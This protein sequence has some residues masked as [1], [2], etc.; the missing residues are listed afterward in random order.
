M[1]SIDISFNL[2]KNQCRSNQPIDET[3]IAKIKELAAQKL[4]DRTYEDNDFKDMGCSTLLVLAVKCGNVAIVNALLEHG[5]LV[6]PN[7]RGN[8]P[9]DFLFH[10]R[11]VN[12]QEIFISLISRGACFNNYKPSQDAAEGIIK[13]K[14]NKL[15]SILLSNYNQGR[16]LDLNLIKILLKGLDKDALLKDSIKNS[17]KPDQIGLIYFHEIEKQLPQYYSIF[18]LAIAINNQDVLK[19][20]DDLNLLNIK[21]LE[22]ERLID[23]YLTACAFGN[24]HFIRVF[25]RSLGKD[26]DVLGKLKDHYNRDVDCFQKGFHTAV[27][28]FLRS[29]QDEKV[30]DFFLKNLDVS[31]LTEVLEA[32][33]YKLPFD[34]YFGIDLLDYRIE[35]RKKIEERIDYLIYL[36]V[37]RG[38]DVYKIQEEIACGGCVLDYRARSYKIK[39]TKEKIE[40]YIDECFS[41]L[42]FCKDLEDV[43]LEYIFGP[44]DIWQ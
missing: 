6:G 37:I 43:I 3:L 11:A 20:F 36:L 34:E 19:I 12:I 44:K 40:K 16:N 42:N 21:N 9:L 32:A 5:A 30:I 17:Q 2:V 25:F 41:N 28:Y 29:R 14:L 15:C 10:N 18:L 35:I 38:A 39:Q 1:N 33:L 27:Y 22:K 31:F 23:L 7:D 13:W 26:K 8:S 24:L 4:I